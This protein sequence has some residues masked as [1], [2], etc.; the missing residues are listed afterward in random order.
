MKNLILIRHAKSSWDAPLKDIDRPL[1]NRGI[2]DAHL[3]ASNSISFFPKTFLIYSSPAKRASETAL[4]F[5]QTI[6]YPLEDIIF[7]N[8]LYTFD[9]NHL[10]DFIK[11]LNNINENVIIFGHNE[12]ITNFVNKFG[13]VL[14]AN[15]ATSGFVALKFDTNNW[16]TL[17]KGKTTKI[18]FPKDLK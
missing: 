12:A 6:S 3:V 16:N 14:I 2:K 10:E 5:A 1:D 9:E 18:I 7:K 11:N 13:D 8:Q 4:I 17:K 15:V